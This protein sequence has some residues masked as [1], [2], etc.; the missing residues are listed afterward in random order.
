VLAAVLWGLAWL[1]LKAIAAGGL[2]GLALTLVAAA[3][4][5]LAV[6]PAAWRGRRASRAAGRPLLAIAVL[7]GYANLSF[8][9]ALVHGE[10]VRVMVL[11][12]LLP[13]WAAVGGRLFLGERL[14]L[15]RAGAV[16]LAVPGVLLTLGGPAALAAPPAG[17]DLLALSSGIAFAL[18]NLVFRAHPGVP[19]AG[20]VAAMQ[21]GSAAM[22]ATALAVGPEATTSP[23]LVTVAGALAYGL[24]WLLLATLGTQ[25]GVTHLPAARASVII[26][27][28]LV[29][30]AVSATWLG[31]ESWSVLKGAGVALILAATA[32][33]GLAEGGGSARGD[34]RRKATPRTG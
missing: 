30:A 24:G 29:T 25:W 28:E 16:T 18:N 19:L 31:A 1:P 11:F 14:T 2:S 4:A 22:A 33:Q 10:V 21:L 34:D 9:L 7:G 13:V 15:A 17:A 8:A 32:L 26:T 3:A 12:Y 6:L 27:L 5:G 20:K 23:P